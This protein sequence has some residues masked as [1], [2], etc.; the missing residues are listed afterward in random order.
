MWKMANFIYI[1][2]IRD[3]FTETELTYKYRIF[4]I[5]DNSS[6]YIVYYLLIFKV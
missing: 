6:L 1:K 2:L 5:L 4:G 3:I